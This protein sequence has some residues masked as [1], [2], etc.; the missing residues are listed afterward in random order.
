MQEDTIIQRNLFGIDDE[1]KP[2]KSPT[3]IPED[4]STATL[5]EESQKRPRQRKNSTN[6]ISKFKKRFEHGR[7]T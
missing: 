7:K 6:L 4:L 1:P 5:K 2:P 3:Q